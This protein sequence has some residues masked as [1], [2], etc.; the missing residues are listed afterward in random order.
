[1]KDRSPGDHVLRAGDEALRSEA[2]AIRLVRSVRSRLCE[3]VMYSPLHGQICEGRDSHRNVVSASLRRSES[4]LSEP[5]PVICRCLKEV[6]SAG[7]WALTDATH[8]EQSA[9][10]F[11]HH[12]ARTLFRLD[13]HHHPVLPATVVRRALAL[14]LAQPQGGRVLL[15]GDGDLV[16][17]LLASLDMDVTVVELDEYLCEFLR[18]L[19]SDVGRKIKIIQGDAA[20]WRPES[21]AYDLLMCDPVN[22]FEYLTMIVDRASEALMPDGKLF[23]SSDPLYEQLLW[24]AAADSFRLQERFLHFNHYYTPFFGISDFTTSL[25]V[26]G[27]KAKRSYLPRRDVGLPSASPMVLNVEMICPTSSH[28][29]GSLEEGEHRISIVDE[30]WGVA[31]VRRVRHE[32]MA[33]AVYLRCRQSIEEGLDAIVTRFQPNEVRLAFRHEG[34]STGIMTTCKAAYRFVRCCTEAGCRS[35]VSPMRQAILNHWPATYP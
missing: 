23:V 1:M 10:A 32:V 33:G 22:S 27:R 24:I 30:T 19:A 25:L 5:D 26:L 13:L 14:K 2:G 29:G 28:R 15:L 7:T 31:L 21:R 18:L 17:P 20:E 34:R 3:Y 16:S 35:F 6:N 9:L 12:G 11:R 8:S 4:L